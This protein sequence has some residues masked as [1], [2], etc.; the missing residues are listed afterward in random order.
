MNKTKLL[1]LITAY[2]LVSFVSMQAQ[3]IKANPHTIGTLIYNTHVDV[4]SARF[5]FFSNGKN[6]QLEFEVKDI[7]VNEN[8][9]KQEINSGSVC[10]RVLDKQKVICDTLINGDYHIV[11]VIRM[12]P[13]KRY[14]DLLV[15]AD[16]SGGASSPPTY[17]FYIFN[18][19]RFIRL[20]MPLLVYID[21]YQLA[22]IN[23]DGI[24]DVTG[25]D[26]MDKLND[27]LHTDRFTRISR[28]RFYNFNEQE[29]KMINVDYLFIDD[30]EVLA[31]KNE[32][33]MIKATTN[34]ERIK[35]E[36][37]QLLEYENEQRRLY[38][39]VKAK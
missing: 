31:Y 21:G 14:S 7:N 6:Y 24:I 23:V 19:H 9:F 33:L 2:L 12:T 15:L 20:K 4:D 36:V 30:H 13:Q 1:V 3:H 32:L 10:V 8:G 28:P 17:E 18:N 22:D 27:L 16:W 34:D 37:L 38:F 29:G 26:F 25:L 5:P 35:M 39:K 11:R